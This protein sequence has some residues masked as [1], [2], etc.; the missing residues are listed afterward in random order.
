MHF[1]HLSVL[2]DLKIKIFYTLMGVVQ[3]RSIIYCVQFIF[4]S[5][6]CC[7]FA[8]LGL[9]L[10]LLCPVRVL[11]VLANLNLTQSVDNKERE[12]YYFHWTIILTNI[13]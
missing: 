5:W 1:L 9:G 8:L 11:A 7:C 12:S 3:Q 2:L 13:N 4:A 10:L 6:G